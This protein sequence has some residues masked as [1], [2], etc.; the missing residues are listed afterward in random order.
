MIIIVSAVIVLHNFMQVSD[1]MASDKERE[2]I[3]DDG[4]LA[5]VIYFIINYGQFYNIIMNAFL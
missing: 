2:M 1:F 4:Q 3:G 5:Q